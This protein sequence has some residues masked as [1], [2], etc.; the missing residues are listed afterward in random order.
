MGGHFHAGNCVLRGG[1]DLFLVGSFACTK[2]P[3]M[4]HNNHSA[5]QEYANRSVVIFISVLFL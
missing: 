3:A 4:E 2:N 1:Q 5:E